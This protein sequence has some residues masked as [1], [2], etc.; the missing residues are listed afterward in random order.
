MYDDQPW[1]FIMQNNSLIKLKFDVQLDFE[2]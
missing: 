1:K 2:G